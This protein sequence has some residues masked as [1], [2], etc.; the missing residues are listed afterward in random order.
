MHEP[1][2][3]L[4][5]IPVFDHTTSLRSEEHEWE[6]PFRRDRRVT[7]PTREEEAA[8][9]FK[10]HIRLAARR[11]VG[12]G[13][14]GKAHNDNQSW[15]LMKALQHPAETAP[16]K[17][18]L[19]AAAQHYRAT[20]WTAGNTASLSGTEHEPGRRTTL[21]Q[22]VRFGSDGGLEYVGVR[23]LVGKA[24]NDNVA[25]TNDQED[26]LAGQIDAA[27]ELIA[28]RMAIGPLLRPFEDAVIHGQSLTAIGRAEGFAN[29]ASAAAAGKA[30]VY[31]GLRV[32]AGTAYL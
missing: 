15:P 4:N 27:N 32:V 13:W 8:A 7:A 26:K 18:R 23:V 1:K 12:F 24:A 19:L 14:N 30:L 16:D 9:I 29:D 25:F 21:D 10:Q 6:A 11:T 5:D 28:M 17:N 2:L 22:R 31:R 20:E 3:N